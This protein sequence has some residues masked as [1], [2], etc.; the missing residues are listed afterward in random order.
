MTGREALRAAV[1][2]A[3]LTALLS[4]GVACE[5]SPAYHE[6]TV[7]VVA[8]REG[9]TC[10]SPSETRNANTAFVVKDATGDV[11][12]RGTVGDPKADSR[13]R[14]RLC[15]SYATVSVPDST[16]YSINVDGA[17]A[18]SFSRSDIEQARWVVLIPG[19]GTAGPAVP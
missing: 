8:L 9:P 4:L 10:S 18:A 11:G 14:V 19:K 1:V 6:L 12:A 7:R 17:E 15:S 5:R 2:V 13:E 16:S 3:A